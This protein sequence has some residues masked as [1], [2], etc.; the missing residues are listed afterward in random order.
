[1]IENLENETW[2]DIVGYEK[3]YQISNLGRVKSLDRFINHYMG[4]FSLIKGHLLK[5]RINSRGYV[6]VV[7]K[8]NTIAKS[9]V[10]HRL[11]AI[12]FIENKFNKPIINHKNGIKTD[13]RLE[14]LEWS[15]YSENTKH[16]FDNNL[17]NNLKGTSRYNSKLTIDIVKKIRKNELN[18]KNKDLATL[19][20]V[21]RSLIT[22]V[23]QNKTWKN[24]V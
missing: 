14:N 16:A 8:K 5:T 24:Y 4:G 23:M 13:N 11:M 17:I 12:A 21:S 19:Y 18:L 1:M 15:T 22:N 7:L 2:K 20:G 3:S 6:G 9:F 10:V